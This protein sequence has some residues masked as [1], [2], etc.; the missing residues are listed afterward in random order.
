MPTE[1]PKPRFP[2]TVALAVAAGVLAVGVAVWGATHQPSSEEPGVAT[3]QTPAATPQ[4]SPSPSDEP[5]VDARSRLREALA[6]WEDADTGAFTQTSV[7]P[8]VGTLTLTGVYRLSTRSSEATQVFA[9]TTDEGAGPVEVRFL[10]SQG[11]TYLNS[12]AW[13]PEIRGCWMRFDAHA[14][15]NA[16]GVA[17]ANGATSLPA[18]VVAL[19]HARA[20]RVDPANPEVV[21]GTV[22]L[23]DAAPLFGS[24]LVRAL[25][26]T[27]LDALVT[28]EFRLVEGEVLSWR[29]GGDSMVA[30][31]ESALA[32]P[33][34]S[35]LSAVAS[36][37]VE[38]E[39]DGVG[40][41]EV[42]V[43]LPAR[44]L[45]MTQAQAQSGVGC[46]G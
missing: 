5:P 40:A 42:D 46:R 45:R 27:A 7:I 20:T 15:A 38:V 24:G 19:S 41:T 44:K 11:A 36:Y 26:D 12:P 25:R 30:A 34:E 37:D 1:R 31:L 21:V 8:G 17:L 32:A 18:N 35:V 39:Y 28:A 4:P 43:L 23:T 22:P 10:G 13:G 2:A 16:T 6:R 14:L 29:I 3:P 9:A 33:S